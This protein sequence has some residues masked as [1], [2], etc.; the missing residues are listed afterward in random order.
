M[1]VI[2]FFILLGL[3]SFVCLRTTLAVIEFK[4]VLCMIS[5]MNLFSLSLLFSHEYCFWQKPLSKTLSD[6]CLARERFDIKQK[7]K[8]MLNYYLTRRRKTLLEKENKKSYV[9]VNRAFKKINKEKRRILWVWICL[10]LN[11]FCNITACLHVLFH[12]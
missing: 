2:I 5:F 1:S 6:F 10:S 12:T 11:I 9:V 7:A 8:R 3:N 4:N